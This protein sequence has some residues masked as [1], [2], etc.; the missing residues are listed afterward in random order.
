MIKEVE[1]EAMRYIRCNLPER[2]R[3]VNTGDTIE[4]YFQG[5]AEFIFYLYDTDDFKQGDI[6]CDRPDLGY[7][8]KKCGSF[9]DYDYEAARKWDLE[10]AG[11]ELSSLY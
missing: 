4:V 8:S 1:E 7:D 5:R 10:N 9:L 11:C 3:E 2:Q 6:V